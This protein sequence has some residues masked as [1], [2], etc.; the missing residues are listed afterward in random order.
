MQLSAHT[1]LSRLLERD[2]SARAQ[3][4]FAL[5]VHAQ[6]KDQLKSELWVGLAMPVELSWLREAGLGEERVGE[7]SLVKGRL[8][9]TIERVFAKVT[10]SSEERSP[11]GEAAREALH[12]LITQGRLWRGHMERLS[13]ALDRHGLCAQLE[14]PQGFDREA[15]EPEGWL[16]RRLEA[17][18]VESGE[19]L[20][21]I[22]PHDLL[23]EPLD[24]PT[25]ERL[26][27]ELPRELKLSD[28]H[29]QLSYD[30]KRRV[31]LLTQTGGTRKSAPPAQWLPR[32][33][34]LEVRL[35]QGQHDSLLRARR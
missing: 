28:A 32:F 12:A 18:G 30:I 31:V 10:L 35:K 34:G 22:E 25:L 26:N 13:E 21:L 7:V 24:E 6:G 14:D 23:P 19:D 16:K 17:L 27:K 11:E 29:Y 33:K 4:L 15:Y 8:V 5:D 20:E 9:A 3:A 2:P 1:S